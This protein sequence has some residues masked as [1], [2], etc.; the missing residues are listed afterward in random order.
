MR[1]HDGRLQIK[2]QLGVERNNDVLIIVLTVFN[3]ILDFH[4]M[5]GPVNLV[6]LDPFERNLKMYEIVRVNCI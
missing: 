2:S 6:P 1:S 4:A 5:L 3:K